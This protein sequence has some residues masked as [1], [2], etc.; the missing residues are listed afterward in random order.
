M[1]WRVE[2]DCLPRWREASRVSYRSM[3]QGRL[4]W[5]EAFRISS[6]EAPMG[7]LRSEARREPDG[8]VLL[9]HEVSLDLAALR[10]RLPFLSA[11]LSAG[12]EP[13][14][15]KAVEVRLKMMLTSEYRLQGFSVDG[16][17]GAL[18]VHGHGEVRPEG[19][20][21]AFW[22]TDLSESRTLVLPLEDPSRPLPF[23]VSPLE[24][25]PDLPVGGTWDMQVVN[26]L[27]LAR[28]VLKARVAARE[29]I[30]VGGRW[31]PSRRIE[32]E[33]PF[34]GTVSAWVDERGRVLRQTVL[35][36]T[37]ERIEGPGDD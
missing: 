11:V 36:L 10:D 37:F 4:P 1:A 3:L 6:G 20:A 24:S 18:P 32:V 17:V 16:K 8:G 22:S 19:L 31:T 15:G 5:H 12:P 26:P 21:C 30:V 34:G 27:T 29:G 14:P 28:E 13:D 25:V 7:T 35:G 33:H 23:G 2:R 9:I